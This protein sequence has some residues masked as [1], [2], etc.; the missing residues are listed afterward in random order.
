[1]DLG[2]NITLNDTESISDPEVLAI[3]KRIIPNQA[4]EFGKI[5][6][7]FIPRNKPFETDEY[8]VL[9]RNFTAPEV[10]VT[11]T[12]AGAD[13]DTDS[14][15]TALPVSALTIDRITIGDILLVG[16]EVVVVKSVDR[17]GNTIDVY[18][19]GAGESAAA[20]HGVA[21]VIAKVI[22]SAHREGKVDGEAIAEGTGKVTN[23]CELVEEIIDLSKANTDQARKYGRTEDVLKQEALERIEAKLARSAVYGVARVGTAAIPAMSRGFLS[24]LE[25]VTGAL[26]TAVNGAFTETSLKNAFD[27]IRNK[28]GFAN[29]V[30]MS[31]KNKRVFNTFTG[32]DQVQA[33]RAD[34]VGGMVLDAYLVD[35]MGAVPAIVDLD[36]PNDRVAII[37]TARMQKGW[38]INDILRFVKENNVNSRENKQTLQGKYGFSMDGIGSTHELLTGLTT[39]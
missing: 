15:I 14:D 22:G 13:W 3:N 18:E 33:Q 25:N 4:K 30:V 17:T 11:A 35:G 21:E 24:Y 34:R 6:D 12:G 27:D 38:K 19:R 7:L 39:S 29:A 32:A 8:E 28:G 37:N 10:S 1:M 23:Y 2:L 16:S 5:W 20:A 26:K 31:V 9:T 36:M